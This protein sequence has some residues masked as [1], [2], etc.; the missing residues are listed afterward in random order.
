MENLFLSSVTEIS[1]GSLGEELDLP[2]SDKVIM[3]LI[4]SVDVIQNVQNIK[5]SLQNTTLVM[6]LDNAHPGFTRLRLIA[7]NDK[8]RFVRSECCESTR[9]GL[10]LSAA[11]FIHNLRRYLQLLTCSY[12]GPVYRIKIRMLILHFASELNIYPTV[13]F[14]G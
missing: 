5:Q 10:Y 14:R 1:S 6:E 13:Q 4:N 3:F 11:L 7:E 8:C 9:N 2:G 12:T